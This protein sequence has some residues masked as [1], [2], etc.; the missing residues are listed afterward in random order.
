VSA[1]DLILDPDWH[2]DAL[3]LQAGQAVF[4]KASRSL[5]E[6]TPFLDDRLDRSGLK[7]LSVSLQDLARAD[8]PAPARSPVFIWHSAFCG[9]TL[10]ARLL[11]GTGHG[12]CLREPGVLMALSSLKRH[13]HAD[14]FRSLTPVVFKALAHQA[15]DAE[16]VIFKPTNIVNN[17]I[18]EAAQIFPE[19]RNIFMTSELREFLISIAKKNESGRAFARRIYAMFAR[20]GLRAGSIPPDQTLSLTDMQIA[21]LVWLMEVEQMRAAQTALPTERSAWLDG[22]RFIGAPAPALKAASAYFELGFDP[23]EID[24][25]VSG[26]TLNRDAKDPGRAYG[27]GDRAREADRITEAMGPDLQRIVDWAFKVLPDIPRADYLAR[28]LV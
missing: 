3:D 21:A 20:D 17:L 2:L 1:R 8:I 7:T 13:N 5:L 19:S 23:D 24:T 26:P 22:D 16:R 28:A 12:L 25:L 15:G 18:L 11:S 4:V 6:E 9:S 10:L 27:A 14:A